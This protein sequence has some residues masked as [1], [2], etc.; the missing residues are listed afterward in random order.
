VL[1]LAR[2]LEIATA[3]KGVERSEQFEALRAAGVDFAQG[4]LFGHP[5]P[6]CEFDLDAA[7]PSARHVARSL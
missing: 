6:H 7:I 5:V 2:G 3:A 4:Y 1:A